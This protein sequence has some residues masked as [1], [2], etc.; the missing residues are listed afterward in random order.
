MI[1]GVAKETFPSERRVALV[2]ASVPSLTKVGLEVLIEPG[3]GVEAGY[4]DEEYVEK[5]A[6]LAADRV[7]VFAA[8]ILLQVRSAGAA[9][10]SGLADLARLR[11]GQVVIGMCDPLGVPA[12]AKQ[13]ADRGV[14]LF[15]LELLPRITRAQSMDILS[16]MATV[17]G[18]RAVLLAATTLPKMFPMMMTAAGTVNPARV[19]IVGAGVAGLQAIATAHRLGAV[20]SAYDVRSAV[21]EQVKSLGGRFVEMELGAAEGEG[22]YAKQMDEVFYEKQRAM[23]LRVVSESHAVITTAAVPGKKSPTLV[24][25]AMVDAMSP[26]SVI[27]DLAAERG[28]NCEL[29]V[30]GKTIVH[31]GVTILGPTNLPSEI[32]FDASHLYSRNISTFLLHLVKEKQVQFDMEDEI[33]RD[34]LVTR[35]GQV[36]LARVSELLAAARG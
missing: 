34:T 7:A 19:F 13:W 6:K 28:G 4:P 33:V 5:G 2:P 8:D 20:V 14:A 30:P 29:T 3:A 17:A 27:V 15:S 25:A 32:P 35:D 11:K 36:V 18:Y 1:V 26:G 21:K 9:G 24:T 12:A 23:M 10:E 16:S 22:G 31:K